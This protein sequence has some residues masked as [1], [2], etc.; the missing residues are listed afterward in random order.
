MWD[1]CNQFVVNALTGGL[2]TLVLYLTI[3]KRSFG[4]L[5]RAR[6]RF[7]G[8]RKQEWLFWC[9]GSV[10]FANIV[11]HFGINY[12][13]HLS[14]C[15]FVL[16]VCIS[17]STLDLTRSAPPR[18]DAQSSDDVNSVPDLVGAG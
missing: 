14:M 16:L 15:L 12:M 17:A 2:V 8:D 4:A 5:G 13:V 6:K 11:A 18:V 9:L 3:F 1:L 10:L 7:S